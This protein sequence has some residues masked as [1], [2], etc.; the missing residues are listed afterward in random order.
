MHDALENG[1]KDSRVLVPEV[2]KTSDND[3][4]AGLKIARYRGSLAI[5]Y[6][7]LMLFKIRQSQEVLYKQTE[8][9]HV[10]AMLQPQKNQ[11]QLLVK[12]QQLEESNQQLQG[13]RSRQQM[14]LGKYLEPDACFSFC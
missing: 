7:G 2:V 10:K 12:C 14:G 6:I 1:Q 11:E 8:E 5:S 3:T 9:N 4:P 13:R